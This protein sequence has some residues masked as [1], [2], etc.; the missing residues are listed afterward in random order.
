MFALP[1]V[2]AQ[3]FNDPDCDPAT[4]NKSAPIF[5]ELNPL[6][7]NQI[8]KTPLQVGE[9]AA[10]QNLTLRGGLVLGQANA[11]ITRAALTGPAIDVESSNANAIIARSSGTAALAANGI[12]S[13]G[14]LTA[15][16]INGNALYS[17]SVSG[18]A[19]FF[20]GKVLIGSI[21]KPSNILLQKGNL[22]LAN[23]NLAVTGAL[24]VNGQPVSTGD[25]KTVTLTASVLGSATRTFTPTEIIGYPASGSTG[26]YRPVW[27][28]AMYMVTGTRVW[29]PLVPAPAG[30]PVAT[31]LFFTEC[32][33]ANFDGRLTVTNPNASA[34]TMK[35][36][37]AYKLETVD[38]SNADVTPPTV[39]M[40][41]PTNGQN[42]SG[43]NFAVTGTHNDSGGSGFKQVEL[44][45]DGA[46]TLPPVTYT[47]GSPYSLT[48]DTTKY[49][50]GQHSVSVRASDNAGNMTTTP[51]LNVS[52]V[53]SAGI[54]CGS[55]ICSG[56]TPVCCDFLSCNGT[57]MC[58]SS[59]DSC[60]AHPQICS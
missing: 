22:T 60:S 39:T 3:T 23:G 11:G 27:Y 37:I 17:N 59:S 57:T 14:G 4:C 44:L 49:S 1:V 53:N 30:P 18:N 43:V 15:S 25:V 21:A 6:S 20:E 34:V 24:T 35:V 31:N 29:R 40:T 19:A 52:I 45:V 33:G 55:L 48:W 16:S 32:T 28:Q 10:P 9:A 8:I 51:A 2:F 56:G 36:T 7:T 12:A 26:A 5:S 46:P 38:C 58:I 54:A 47:A 13:A 50:D 42:V 41:A